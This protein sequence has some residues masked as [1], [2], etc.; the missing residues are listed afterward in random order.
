MPR[1]IRG[2]VYDTGMIYW[3]IRDNADDVNRCIFNH[4]R[5]EHILP[6]AEVYGLD[7]NSDGI[8]EVVIS[9]ADI[10]DPLRKKANEQILAFLHRQS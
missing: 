3:E 6:G 1:L 2:V 5:F 8:C 7:E 9:V 10:D 4:N